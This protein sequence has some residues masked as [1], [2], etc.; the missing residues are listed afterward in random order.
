MEFTIREY[1]EY[2]EAEILRL[3]ESVGWTNYTGNPGMLK[4]AYAHS[5]KTVQPPFV[6]R[7]GQVSIRIPGHA[8]R[9]EWYLYRK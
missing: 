8:C 4:N 7:C 1:T 9:R 5:L 2:R 3:Y 6:L